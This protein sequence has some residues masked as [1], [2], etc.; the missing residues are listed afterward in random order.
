MTDHIDTADKIA[1]IEQAEPIAS[2]EANEPTEPTDSV[3]PTE[4]TESTEPFEAIESSESS[5]ARDHFEFRLAGSDGTVESWTTRHRR[6]RTPSPLRP[7]GARCSLRFAR[8][9]EGRFS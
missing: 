3:E 1:P 6:V 2:T 8:I 5:D 9:G 4:P 7:G